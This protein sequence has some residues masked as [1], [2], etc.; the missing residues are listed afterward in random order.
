MSNLVF[1]IKW[2]DKAGQLQ[3]KYIDNFCSD[4]VH[5]LICLKFE[6]KC[7]RIFLLLHLDCII[8]LQ[9]HIIY[10]YDVQT[11]SQD[12]VFTQQVNVTFILLTI[13]L[14]FLPLS[15]HLLLA[16]S[17]PVPLSVEITALR[18][19][20]LRICWTVRLQMV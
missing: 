17:L 8:N 9:F 18:L 14:P 12:S 15:L 2:R 4:E 1:T 11:A 16:L 13:F 10:I 3:Y 19:H 7:R 6:H 20:L 5:A